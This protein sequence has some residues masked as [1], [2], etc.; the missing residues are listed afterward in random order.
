MNRIGQYPVARIAATLGI[1]P[2]LVYQ[3][4][5]DAMT[6]CRDRVFAPETKRSAR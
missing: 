3:L 4:L 2:S 1:S 6:H 5:R